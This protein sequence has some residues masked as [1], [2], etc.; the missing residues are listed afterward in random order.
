MINKINISKHVKKIH[1]NYL[2]TSIFHMQDKQD[3]NHICP[4]L[5]HV[6]ICSAQI[7]FYGQEERR[8][9]IIYPEAT[10]PTL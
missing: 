2:L 4:S 7:V 10:K 6:E 5:L 9:L 3:F 1:K 8:T